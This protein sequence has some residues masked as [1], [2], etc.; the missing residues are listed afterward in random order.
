M[1]LLLRILLI[2][3]PGLV[4]LLELVLVVMALRRSHLLLLVLHRIC[5]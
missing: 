4:F 1:P 2:L 5:L 3:V